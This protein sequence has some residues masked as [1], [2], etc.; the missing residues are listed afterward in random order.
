MTTHP[1]TSPAADV[2]P[3][4]GHSPSSLDGIKG[5]ER[6]SRASA[7]HAGRQRRHAGPILAVAAVAILGVAGCTTP[8]TVAAAP[9]GIE[10]TGS[11]GVTGGA[12]RAAPGS[13]Q[14]GAGSGQSLGAVFANDPKF[15]TWYSMSI[16][17]NYFQELDGAGQYTVFAPVNAAFNKVPASLVLADLK[18]QD[19][20]QGP[21][22][23]RIQSVVRNQVVDGVVGPDQ[24][25]PGTRL[26]VLNGYQVVVGSNPGNPAV[27]M[28][29]PRRGGGPNIG[30][31]SVAHIVGAPI[32]AANGIVY[33]VDTLF[34]R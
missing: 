22:V 2:R 34:A 5:L 9:S 10:T 3:L 12:A 20:E 27:T 19:L 28:T 24:L 4:P 33:P 17:G 13:G 15:S 21:N 23:T 25:R 18:G 32:Q 26:K 6:A 31:T 14:V 1:R 30:G 11:A 8:Q 29:T 7:R 16:Q